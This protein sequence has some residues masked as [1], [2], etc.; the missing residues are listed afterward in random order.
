MWRWVHRPRCPADLRAVL[1]RD[2]GKEATP[3][4]V[5]RRHLSQRA[6]RRFCS[7]KALVSGAR[8]LEK[9]SPY[10]SALLRSV[11]RNYSPQLGLKR[12]DHNPLPLVIPLVQKI[13]TFF[14]AR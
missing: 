14:V 11:R 3:V 8:D 1:F 12:R 2:R 10:S 7:A 6:A 9:L 13:F 4:G 5:L